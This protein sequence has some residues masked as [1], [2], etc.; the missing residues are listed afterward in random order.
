MRK[1]IDAH[2]HIL[3]ETML[4]R[5]DSALKTKAEKFGIFVYENGETCRRVPPYF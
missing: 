3:P 5:T 2:V 4:G 1:A